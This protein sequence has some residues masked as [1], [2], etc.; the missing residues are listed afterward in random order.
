MVQLRSVQYSSQA[1][2]APPPFLSRY[3]R[4]AYLIIVMT[5]RSNETN[6]SEVSASTSTSASRPLAPCISSRF[7]VFVWRY[8]LFFSITWMLCGCLPLLFFILSE[9]A[10]LSS[11]ITRVPASTPK[12]F[13]YA[14]ANLWAVLRDS[15]S[16]PLCTASVIC[17]SCCSH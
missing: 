2:L 7:L 16:S 1:K 4:H 12:C 10:S 9:I 13:C 11:I 14:V 15:G 5:K 3:Y 6:D 17:F 8:F